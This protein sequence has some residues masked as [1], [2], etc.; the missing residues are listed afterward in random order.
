M[1]EMGV[2]FEVIE[3]PYPYVCG[4]YICACGART[5]RYGD[6][7]AVTPPSWVVTQTAGEPDAVCPRCAEHR[8]TT[9]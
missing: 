3:T 9:A 8:A 6:E 1:C 2:A 5:M 4:V 7:A